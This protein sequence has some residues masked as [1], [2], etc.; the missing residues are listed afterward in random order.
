M[1]DQELLLF[2]DCLQGNALQ[3]KKGSLSPEELQRVVSIEDLY[4]KRIELGTFTYIFLKKRI[5]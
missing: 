5:Y 4:K 1:L 3:T 2:S